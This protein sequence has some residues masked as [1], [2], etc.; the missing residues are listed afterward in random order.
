MSEDPVL[1][2]LNMKQSNFTDDVNNFS[3]FD[4]ILFFLIILHN[5]YQ[6][7]FKEKQ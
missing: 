2:F 5:K 7:K 6:L 4:E 1:L 3:L